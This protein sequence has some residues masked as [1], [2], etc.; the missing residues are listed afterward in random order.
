MSPGRA[1]EE[2]EEETPQ[3]VQPGVQPKSV[4]LFVA[5]DL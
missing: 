3:R 5:W 4:M 2:V 1:L